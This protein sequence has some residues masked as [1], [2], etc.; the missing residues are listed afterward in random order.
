MTIPTYLPY[1]VL[2]GAML[3]VVT[4]LYALHRSIADAGWSPAVAARTF[5]LSALILVAWFIAPIA[6]SA[7]GV[8]DV[9]ENGVPTIQYAIFL[10]ILIG[11]VLIWRSKAVQR[12]IDAVPQPW[13]VGVQFYRALG[14]VFLGL[15]ATDKLPGLFALPAGIGDVITGLLAPV[16]ALAYAR[17]PKRAA[18]HVRA[19]NIFGILDLTVAVGAAFATAPSAIGLITVHPNSALM[20]VLPMSVIPTFLVPLSIVLHVAS[21]AKLKRDQESGAVLAAA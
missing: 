17:S 2:T 1:T 13:L 19:W 8:F 14:V 20:T 10:P 4:A 9:D 3:T 11:G 16:V 6:L 18:G 5:R 7:S 21:L 15:Y 12:L